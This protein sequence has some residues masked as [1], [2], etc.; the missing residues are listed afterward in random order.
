MLGSE[1]HQGGSPRPPGHPLVTVTPCATEAV[2]NPQ[3][4]LNVERTFS[5]AGGG[6]IYA[7]ALSATASPI[8][9]LDIDLSDF[10]WHDEAACRR[11][12]PELFFPG[13]G[14]HA[15]EAKA[16]CARCPVRLECL[17]QAIETDA[18]G[19]WGGTSE[20]ERRALKR[21]D[22]RFARSA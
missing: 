2:R 3:P 12:D 14:R 5:L 19:I 20:E 18:R 6:A 13:K 1:S 21:R 15:S 10:D 4:S 8:S 16:T 7:R 11:V 9:D 22:R 17:N